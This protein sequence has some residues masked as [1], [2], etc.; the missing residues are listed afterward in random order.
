MVATDW[1]RLLRSDN[2]KV[3]L[4]SPGFLRTGLGDDRESGHGKDK[5]A[6][7]AVDP[8]VGAEFCAD[9]VEG[10]RDSQSWPPQAFRRTM[11]QPW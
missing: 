10:K 4:V 2:V 1:A 7:G 8:A 9:I 5:G 3:F 11:V 6:L